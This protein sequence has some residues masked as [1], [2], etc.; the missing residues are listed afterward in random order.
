MIDALHWIDEI[1]VAR[2]ILTY[3]EAVRGEYRLLSSIQLLA[4][5]SLSTI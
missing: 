3:A 4:A 2:D 1:A 5:R